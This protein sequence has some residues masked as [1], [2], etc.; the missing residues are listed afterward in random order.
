MGWPVLLHSW[1]FFN[2]CWSPS[3]LVGP[4]ASIGGR[5]KPS[6]G[7]RSGWSLFIG[8]FDHSIFPVTG[9][10]VLVPTLLRSLCSLCQ[11]S[12]RSGS[13][14]EGVPLPEPPPLIRVS[15]VLASGVLKRGEESSKNSFP[16]VHSRTIISLS[17]LCCFDVKLST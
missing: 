17:K 11:T 1:V 7:T 4:F 14:T 3:A 13:Y 2:H 15:A 16:R 12:L 5:K 8:I 10:T 9:V 6:R